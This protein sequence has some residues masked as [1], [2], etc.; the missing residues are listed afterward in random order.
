MGETMLNYTTYTIF[1]EMGIL[2]GWDGNALHYTTYTTIGSWIS[3]IMSAIRRCSVAI[4][5]SYVFDYFRFF[6]FTVFVMIA[7]RRCS[8]AIRSSY[9]FV[10]FSVFRLYFGLRFS[11][12]PVSLRY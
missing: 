7:T 4:R 3:V 1:G 6:V 5:S 2:V 10:S 8:V 12:F 9:V 11:N